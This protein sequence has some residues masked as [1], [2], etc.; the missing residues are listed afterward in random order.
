MKT[1]L[2][3]YETRDGEA[4]YKNYF[5]IKGENIDK[6]CDEA[7]LVLDDWTKEQ[8]EYRIYKTDTAQ[9]IS[10]EDLKIIK[11]YIPIYDEW[12]QG[13]KNRHRKVVK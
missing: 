11:K 6:A 10:E 9:E 2:I 1:Y 13:L 3:G 5:T 4:E 7:Q 8:G 12:Y